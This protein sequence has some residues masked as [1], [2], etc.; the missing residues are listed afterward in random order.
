MKYLILFV[1]TVWWALIG[2]MSPIDV[3][4]RRPIHTTASQTEGSHGFHIKIIG[5]TD[6]D[7]Y[8][9]GKEYKGRSLLRTILLFA[10][11]HQ[12]VRCFYTEIL[13]HSA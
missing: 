2:A 6:K 12:R 8:I 1:F 11:L 4:E 13:F 9:P 5:L 3:C 10:Y 7:Q